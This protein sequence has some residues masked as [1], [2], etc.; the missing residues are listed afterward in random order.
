MKN[1]NQLLTSVKN[2]TFHGDRDLQI[3]GLTIDSRTVKS[4]YLYAAMSGTQ[5]DG[6]DFIEK[7]IEL[8]AKAILHSNEVAHIEGISYIKVADVSEALG[9]ISLQFYD[10]AADNLIIVGTTGT[11]GKTTISTL[12]FELFTKL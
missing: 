8:G 2:A 4:N 11:N 7:A 3:H 12:L 1:L 10:E 9:Q 6:H 5:V